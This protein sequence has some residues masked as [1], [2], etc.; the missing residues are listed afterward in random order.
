MKNLYQFIFLIQREDFTLG[1]CHAHEPCL[2]QFCEL[3]LNFSGNLGYRTDSLISLSVKKLFQYFQ[4]FSSCQLKHI[5]W[6][7]LLGGFP[8]L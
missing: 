5:A 1:T 7:L 2:S 4:L 3:P 8:L 6:L